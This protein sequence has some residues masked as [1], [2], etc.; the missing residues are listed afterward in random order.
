MKV[1]WFWAGLSRPYLRSC[2]ELCNTTFTF[3]IPFIGGVTFYRQT[4][5]FSDGYWYTVGASDTGFSA[6]TDA[7][8][9]T[10]VWAR[11]EFP[12]ANEV[13]LALD[14]PPVWA[15]EQV[16][17]LA[18]HYEIL[19]EGNETAVTADTAFATLKRARGK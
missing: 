14:H 4:R 13:L 1:N 3:A 6:V 2:D 10:S 8:D 15:D 18:N 12:H 17:K 7:D 11:L 16:K 19:T 5:K 9:D